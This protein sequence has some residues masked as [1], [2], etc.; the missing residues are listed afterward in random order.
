[1]SG[2]D[3]LN[4]LA[5]LREKIE[6]VSSVYALPEFN[7]GRANLLILDCVV[8]VNPDRNVHQQPNLFARIAGFIQH[9]RQ[10]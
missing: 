4:G 5:L 3:D 10:P 2:E 1:M 7:R 9:R 6:K 8:V